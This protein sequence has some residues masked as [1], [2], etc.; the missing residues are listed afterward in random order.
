MGEREKKGIPHMR[1]AQAEPQS[2]ERMRGRRCRFNECSPK[3][4]AAHG[5]KGAGWM[6]CYYV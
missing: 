2:V 6:A 4:G 5:R 1:R 3:H